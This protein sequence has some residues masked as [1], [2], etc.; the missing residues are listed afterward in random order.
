MEGK[1]SAP[2][3]GAEDHDSPPSVPSDSNKPQGYHPT[4]PEIMN[5]I[6]SLIEKEFYSESQIPIKT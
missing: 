5:F 3:P 4:Q 6:I 1:A 2:L